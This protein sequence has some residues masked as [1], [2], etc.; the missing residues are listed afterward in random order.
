MAS[1]R[2]NPVLIAGADAIGLA[3]ALGLARRGIAV[4]V[5]EA[6]SRLVEEYRASTFHPP[7]IE[8]LDGLGV[9]APLRA[10]GLVADKFQF[11]DRQTGLISE[12][13][14]EVLADD[15]RYPY[16]LQI[17]QFALVQLV[18]G[19]LV[20][21]PNAQVHFRNR[22]TGLNQTADGVVVTVETPDGPAEFEGCYSIG[23]DGGRSEVRHSLGIEFEGMIYPERY[24]VTFTTFDFWKVMPDLAHVN[25]VSDPEEWFVSLRSPGLWRVLFPT[26]PDETVFDEDPDTATMDGLAQERYQ[27]VWATAEPY[28]ITHRN[29][30]RVHQ[31]VATRYRVGRGLLAGDAA[32]VNNPLGGMGLNGGIHD[33]VMLTDAIGRALESGGDN[34]SLDHYAN[35]RRRIAVQYIQAQ[36][37]QNEQNMHQRDPEV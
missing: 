4:V 1:S 32:H 8:M 23:A 22:V 33:A 26:N 29:V 9:G 17:E 35:E 25:Y 5:L 2:T 14:M 31:R 12:F 21:L 19:D 10:K 15:T 6:E 3:V 37:A 24:L 18:Y 11:R 20:K 16:R 7:T 27:R 28:P 13:D 36:T 34:A 30:Y